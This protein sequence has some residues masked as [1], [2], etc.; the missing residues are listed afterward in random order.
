MTLKVKIIKTT[1]FPVHNRKAMHM[2]WTEILN[3]PHSQFP[4][5]NT[6]CYN[7]R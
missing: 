6:R 3:T 2:N 1:E 7:R 4:N 5:T